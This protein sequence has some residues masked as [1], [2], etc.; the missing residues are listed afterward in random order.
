MLVGAFSLQGY[1]IYLQHNGRKRQTDALA[2]LG[3]HTEDS[4]LQCLH[5]PG[6]ARGGLWP[7]STER[8]STTAG[9]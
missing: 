4:S 9:R 3:G 8:K 1:T 7:D 2:A 5:I 6:R